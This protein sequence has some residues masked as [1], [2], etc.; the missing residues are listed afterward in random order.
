MSSSDLQ[1][2]NIPSE[3]FFIALGFITL[4]GIGLSMR[5][6]V[7]RRRRLHDPAFLARVQRT[8]HAHEPHLYEV[9]LSRDTVV[10]E[11]SWHDIM[12]VSSYDDP[13]KIYPLTS[14]P[15]Y[16]ATGRSQCLSPCLVRLRHFWSPQRLSSQQSVRRITMTL[17]YHISSSVWPTSACCVAS[18]QMFQA[19]GGKPRNIYD[20]HDTVH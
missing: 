11:Y 8:D 5:S 20:P 17:N 13:T 19:S 1:N 10:G 15:S 6:H 7:L 9:F 3:S 14:I 2:N 12:P 18:C 4:I 16:P